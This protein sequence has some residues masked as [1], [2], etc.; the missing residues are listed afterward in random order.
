VPVAKSILKPE[1]LSY[2]IWL[3]AKSHNVEY[4]CMFSKGEGDFRLHYFGKAEF[5]GNRHLTESC[6]ES[7]TRNDICPVNE[8]SGTDV[9]PGSWFHV[10]AVHDH[11]NTTYY[12]NGKQEAKLS[13]PEAWKTDATRSITIGNNASSK[14]RSFDGYLDEARLMTVPKDASWVKL[15]YESQREGQKFLSF[16]N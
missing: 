2:S 13:A 6:L 12:V 4:Q 1:K 5:Y 8:A 7:S 3:N 16:M 10:M 9:K 14:G 15:E 11:P